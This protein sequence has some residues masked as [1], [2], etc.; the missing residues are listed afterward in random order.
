[1]MIEVGPGLLKALKGE[2]IVAFV[3]YNFNSQ[4]QA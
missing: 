2:T 4:R 3:Y 1:M